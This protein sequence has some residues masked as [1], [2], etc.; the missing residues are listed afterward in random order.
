MDDCLTFVLYCLRKAYHRCVDHLRRHVHI[1]DPQKSNLVDIGRRIIN[2]L[3]DNE[4][5]EDLL[6]PPEIPAVPDIDLKRHLETLKERGPAQKPSTLSD[7]SEVS[8][9]SFEDG[10]VWD[11]GRPPSHRSQ[12]PKRSS[13]VPTAADLLQVRGQRASE[14]VIKP[15]GVVR[16]QHRGQ[17]KDSSKVV[18]PNRPLAIFSEEAKKKMPVLKSFLN[19]KPTDKPKSS[20]TTAQDLINFLNTSEMTPQKREL[21]NACQEILEMDV[22]TMGEMRSLMLNQIDSIP[23]K[24]GMK[25]AVGKTFNFLNLFKTAMT[26]T[27]RKT[28]AAEPKLRS[29]YVNAL[30][31]ELKRAMNEIKKLSAAERVLWLSLPE[32]YEQTAEAYRQIAKILDEN[33]LQDSQREPI[34]QFVLQDLLDCMTLID[35]AAGLSDQERQVLFDRCMAAVDVLE[36]FGIET[37]EFAQKLAVSFSDFS[38]GAT[39]GRWQR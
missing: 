12:K 37:R 4:E 18:K 5:D 10:V 22:A 9:D 20:L 8:E 2:I 19:S 23:S 21:V 30:L 38:S 33:V 34:V 26:P 36:W 7:I 39:K 1:E 15:V 29:I 35:P 27:R 31:D 32:N 16:H 13:P 11:V 25:G 28:L 14:F 6:R 17:H 3:A 24:V